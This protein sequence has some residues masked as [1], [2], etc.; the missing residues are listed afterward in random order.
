M[1]LHLALRTIW[2]VETDAGPLRLRLKHFRP[3]TP[4]MV[5][6]ASSIFVY[7][8]EPVLHASHGEKNT[9]ECFCNPHANTQQGLLAGR[10]PAG[11]H[12]KTPCTTAPQNISDSNVQRSV[13]IEKS[14]LQLRLQEEIF[15]QRNGS[16]K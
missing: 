10:F 12:H 6:P 5:S 16:K 3:K 2:T 11:P 15:N 9:H 14:N 13:R 4:R 1:N 8:Q 7:T